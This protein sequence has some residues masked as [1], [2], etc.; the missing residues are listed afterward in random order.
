MQRT[1]RLQ[2]MHRM[3]NKKKNFEKS[4]KCKECRVGKNAKI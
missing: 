1:Q 4:L 3:W 2:R